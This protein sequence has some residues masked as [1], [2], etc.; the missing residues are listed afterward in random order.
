MPD[1]E[2]DL[3]SDL[4]TLDGLFDTF[5]GTAD[6]DGNV[7]V[8]TTL[9]D[10]YT[11]TMDLDDDSEPIIDE[12]RDEDG[13]SSLDPVTSNPYATDEEE[14]DPIQYAPAHAPLSKIKHA[15]LIYED[16]ASKGPIIRKTCITR[17]I[18]EAHCTPAGANTYYATIHSKKR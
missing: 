9:V 5:A 12:E 16:E 3:S 14:D 17:F 18:N 8:L 11:E 13:Y 10:H 4:E 7:F 15:T 2:F 6:D 1:R